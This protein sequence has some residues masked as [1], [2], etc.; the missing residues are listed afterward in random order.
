[1]KKA[2]LT[3]GRTPKSPS[4]APGSTQKPPLGNGNETAGAQPQPGQDMNA[5]AQPPPKKASL[6]QSFTGRIKAIYAGHRTKPED[7]FEPLEKI[8]SRGNKLVAVLEDPLARELLSF[9]LQLR[10]ERFHLPHPRRPAQQQAYIEDTNT[11]ATQE[12]TV[13][14]LFWEQAK[15]TVPECDVNQDCYVGQGW[16]V[17]VKLDGDDLLERMFAG[18]EESFHP[19]FLEALRER[20]TR[21]A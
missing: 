9:S 21:G 11:L 3:Q 18:G 2:S 1:M 13:M 16:K 10:E 17:F 19:G 4:P 7:L 6:A 12:K 14:S 15:A 5:G 8:D 20:M